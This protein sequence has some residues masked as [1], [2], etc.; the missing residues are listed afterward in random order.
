LFPPTAG[1]ADM[2]ETYCAFIC[3]MVLAQVTARP[4]FVA[5]KTARSISRKKR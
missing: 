4:A 5:P 1:R 2:T 3:E